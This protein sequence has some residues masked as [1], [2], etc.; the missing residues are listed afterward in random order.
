M[1]E[2]GA[3]AVMA[4]LCPGRFGRPGP[5]L[6]VS[7]TPFGGR[8]GTYFTA[9][10]RAMTN[11]D[12]KKQK[13]RVVLRPHFRSATRR[14]ENGDICGGGRSRGWK[15]DWGVLI[16]HAKRRVHLARSRVSSVCELRRLMV[17]TGLNDGEFTFTRTAHASLLCAAH[18]CL[19]IKLPRSYLSC[20]D[21]TKLPCL[22]DTHT[23]THTITHTKN[24]EH[25]VYS[26]RSQGVMSR[27]IPSW[28]TWC[29]SESL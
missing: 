28:P 6:L 7:F 27:L 11:S 15:S 10:Y 26:P 24:T 25:T 22:A 20:W 9:F 1:G 14:E 16:R 17:S 18:V 4:T 3:S 23:H 8:G 12:N 2:P 29:P 5:H 19:V 13:T 21:N